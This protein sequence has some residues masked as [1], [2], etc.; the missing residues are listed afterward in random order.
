MTMSYSCNNFKAILGCRSKHF[1]RWT[2]DDDRC[3]TAA[4]H[5][6]TAAAARNQRQHELLS[7]DLLVIWA[8]GAVPAL[9]PLAQV[10]CF[11]GAPIF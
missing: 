5:R 11:F 7:L 4:L 6:A 9:I 2:A 8:F 10:C 1:E 3:G